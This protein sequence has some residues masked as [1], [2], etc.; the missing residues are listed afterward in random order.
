[1]RFNNEIKEEKFKST[2]LLWNTLRLNAPWK[3]GYISSIIK[4]RKFKDKEE[5]KDYYFATGE[6]RLN[7]ISKLPTSS[8]KSLNSDYP[9]KDKT[10]AKYNYNYGR[11]KNE[12]LHIGDLLYEAVLKEGN[13]Y[14]LTRRDCRY[15]AYYRIICETWNGVIATEQKVHNEIINY[16]NKRECEIRLIDTSGDFDNKYAVDFEMYYQGKIICGLQVKPDTYKGNKDYLEKIRAINELK[17]K[18]YKKIFNRDVFYIYAD[19]KGCISNIE[20]LEKAYKLLN[21]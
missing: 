16:F 4:Q 2:N 7:E 12:I 10:I 6:K 13:K 8:Q 18:N 17:F 3:I 11:T 9:S 1:M 15:I 5:W 20:E 19:D 14:E 21:K